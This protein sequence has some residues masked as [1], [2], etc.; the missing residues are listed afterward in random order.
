MTAPRI[1]IDLDKIQH[2]ARSLVDRLAPKGISVTGVTKAFLGTAPLARAMLSGGVS[3][4][5]DS[6]V[7]NFQAMRGFSVEAP[8][9]LIRSPMLSSVDDVVEL[10]DVS[11]N[12]EIAV[13]R[14]LSNAAS[15]RGVT[16]G[17]VLMVELGD[18]REGVMPDDLQGLVGFALSLPGL[19]VAG[20]GTNLACQNGIVP[21]AAKMRELADLVRAAEERFGIELAIVSGGNSA[22]LDWALATDDVGR[23]NDL[24]LGES[25]LL[26]REP[27]HR[28]PIAGLFTDAFCLVAEVIESKVKPARPWGSVAQAAFTDQP[29]RTGTGVLHQGL[30]AVGR[31]DVD[32]AGLTSTNG[33]TILGAS[34]DHLVVAQG[35]ESM[36]VGD[37]LRFDVNY[38]ALV[39]AMTSPFVSRTFIGTGDRTPVAALAR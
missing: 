20:V 32:P 38:S 11:F 2:N 36:A 34:S 19:V 12:T 14:A 1:E 23:V 13:L 31:Q 3:A 4:L 22:S 30:A 24:R 10:V 5:G 7:E 39:R 27:L 37:E 35:S 33:I 25:I 29:L 16:H 26:G 17:V 15:A 6:R 8:S 28:Q 9:R 21:D 18:L